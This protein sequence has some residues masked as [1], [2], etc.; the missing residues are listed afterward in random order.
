[1]EI[2]YERRSNNETRIYFNAVFRFRSSFFCNFYIQVGNIIFRSGSN[3]VK[4]LRLY[5]QIHKYNAGEFAIGVR[6]KF[7]NTLSK[8][9]SKV[10]E[11]CEQVQHWIHRDIDASLVWSNNG[12]D[13]SLFHI[14]KSSIIRNMNI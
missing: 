8:L 7:G 14:F 5:Y 11:L 6:F 3:K 9:W 10:G 1:M 2:L 12:M 4:F 13:S